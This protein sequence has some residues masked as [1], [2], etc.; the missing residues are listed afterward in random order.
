MAGGLQLQMEFEAIDVSRQPVVE[1]NQLDSLLLQV[2]PHLIGGMCEFRDEAGSF[3]AQLL[4]FGDPWVIFY[5][6]NSFGSLLL[7]GSQS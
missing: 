4:Q 7:H 2:R 1:N 6:Q 3:E 5:D